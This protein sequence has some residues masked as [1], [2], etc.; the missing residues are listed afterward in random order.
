M[1]AEGDFRLSRIQ[2]EGWNAA[3]R[4]PASQLSELSETAIEA[5][6]PY[7]VDFERLRWAAGFNN[8]LESWRRHP[9]SR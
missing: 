5:L 2:A 7:S 1:N 4:I 9:G 6:N 3:R 8:A